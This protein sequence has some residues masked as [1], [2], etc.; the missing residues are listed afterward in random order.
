MPA[1]KNRDTPI[2]SY[3]KSCEHHLDKLGP[4]AS[5]AIVVITISTMMARK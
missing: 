2:Q 1:K 4:Q 3:A 5:I